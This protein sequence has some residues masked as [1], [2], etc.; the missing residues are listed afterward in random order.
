VFKILSEAEKAEEWA[1]FEEII[2][3]NLER[4]LD[5]RPAYPVTKFAK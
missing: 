2:Y 3:K 4:I 5:K 1:K